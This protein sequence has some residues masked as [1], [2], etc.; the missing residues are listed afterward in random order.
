M[1]YFNSMFHFDDMLDFDN[2]LDF[3]DM[4]YAVTWVNESRHCK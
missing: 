3:D 4:Y 1:L 2:I